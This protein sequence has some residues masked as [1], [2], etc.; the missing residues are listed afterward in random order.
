MYACIDYYIYIHIYVCTKIIKNVK[1]VLSKPLVALL[2]PSQIRSIIFKAP[3]MF[4]T[5]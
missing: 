2:S 1:I 4:Q 5:V 3:R